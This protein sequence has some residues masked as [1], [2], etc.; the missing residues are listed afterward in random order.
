MYSRE[1]INADKIY[2]RPD[3]TYLLRWPATGLPK[4]TQVLGD[5]DKV[6]EQFDYEYDV[7]I[8]I[9]RPARG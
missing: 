7:P 1:T 4:R 2:W 3:A 5:N 8:T 9:A 6:E